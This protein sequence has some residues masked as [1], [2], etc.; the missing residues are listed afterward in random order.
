MTRMTPLKKYLF[1]FGGA[2]LG[3]MVIAAVVFALLDL[4]GNA[5]VNMGILIA[6]AMAAGHYFLKDHQR[7]PTA[8]E[9]RW[10]VFMSFLVSVLVSLLFVLAVVAMQPESV[11]VMRIMLQENAVVFLVVMLVVSLVYLL[12]LWLGYGFMLD[13][14]FKAMQKKAASDRSS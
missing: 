12:V 14:Q 11:A 9:K 2:N 6:S 13:R 8:A 10:L 1:I 3:L 4:E 5:G 7:L